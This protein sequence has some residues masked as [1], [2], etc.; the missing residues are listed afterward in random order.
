MLCKP[1]NKGGVGLI[2]LMELKR[3]YNLKLGWKIESLWSKWMTD[4]Y[5]ADNF[6][7][8]GIKPIL[9]ECG[10]HSQGE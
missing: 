7:V 9:L 8:M 5:T 1:K 4:R 3:V 6:W 10:K 2:N